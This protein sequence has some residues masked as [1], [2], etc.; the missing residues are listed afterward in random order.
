MLYRSSRS[1]MESI[2]KL[3]KWVGVVWNEIININKSSLEISCKKF[4]W[5]KMAKK[6]QILSK[7]C[8]YRKFEEIRQIK[9]WKTKQNL[10]KSEKWRTAS[11]LVL[12]ILFT[13]TILFEEKSTK[14]RMNFVNNYCDLRRVRN[15]NELKSVNSGISGKTLWNDT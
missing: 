2:W 14:R 15:S 10:Q 7:L 3:W 5:R 8:K 4:R 13:G 9:I 12:Y 1:L 11:E 6:S